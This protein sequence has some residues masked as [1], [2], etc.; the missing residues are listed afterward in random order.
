MNIGG[1]IA[2]DLLGELTEPPLRV[3]SLAPFS[4]VPEFETPTVCF[5]FW[6]ESS[7]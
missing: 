7:R 1:K 4:I 6:R 5:R 3:S 2:F